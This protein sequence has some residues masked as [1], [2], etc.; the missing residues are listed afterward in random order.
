MN[1]GYFM[2]KYLLGV[3]CIL[4]A[5]LCYGERGRFSIVSEDGQRVANVEKNDSL[6]VSLQDQTSLALDLFFIQAQGAPTT[7]SVVTTPDLSTIT[8]VSTTG[9]VAGNRVGVFSTTGKFYFADQIGAPAGLVVTLDTPL[10][11]AFSVGD[12]VITSTKNMNVDGSI[13][14]QTFQIGP[15]SAATG[16]SIDITRVMGYL[17]SA[18]AMDDA[19]FGDL[20]KLTNGIV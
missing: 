5:S 6:A 19:E 13:T 17:Q 3:I 9:F 8:V 18:S 10:D 16:L 7:L 4:A 20:A 12:F 2:R 14:M 11:F 15:F 1:K